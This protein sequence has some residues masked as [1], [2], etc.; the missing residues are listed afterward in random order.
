MQCCQG[1]GTSADEW[2]S[3]ICSSL[4]GASHDAPRGK[5]ARHADIVQLVR[6]TSPSL[7]DVLTSVRQ[8]AAAGQLSWT[9]PE[10]SANSSVGASRHSTVSQGAP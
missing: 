8:L 10:N 3:T 4:A 5:H 9:R 6:I 2:A 7:D 1:G